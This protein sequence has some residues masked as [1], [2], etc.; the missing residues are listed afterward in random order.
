MSELWK[1]ITG[2]Y[3]ISNLGKCRNILTNEILTTTIQNKYLVVSV[4]QNTKTVV[5][6]VHI[7]VANAFV[8]NPNNYKEINH[9]DK[10]K[11]NNRAS[12]LEWVSHKEKKQSAKKYERK[13]IRIDYSGN[14]TIYNSVIEACR[15][16]KISSH[17]IKPCLK[18]KQTSLNGYKWKYFDT[19]IQ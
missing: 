12:N 7:L 3:E 1:S 2:N 18:D 14:E 13:V 17:S 4:L 9:I 19:N 5:E 8:E 6:F 10:N 11:F 16:N 15:I